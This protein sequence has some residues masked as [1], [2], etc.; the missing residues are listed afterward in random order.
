MRAAIIG[1]REPSQ[2]QQLL[3]IRSSQMLSAEGVE[4]VTGAADGIDTCAMDGAKPG[5][6]TVVLPWASYN[7]NKIPSHA[8][9]VVYTQSDSHLLWTQSVSLYHPAFSKLTPGAMAL[10]ARN[11]GIVE[12]VDFVLAFPD[13]SGGGGTAQGIRI[14]VALE[15]PCITLNKGVVADSPAYLERVKELVR[16]L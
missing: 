16:S 1:T 4:I 14:A 3:A 8:R 5:T 2:L 6:L 15:K 11:Y 7:A 9:K 12:L 13:F 10:H